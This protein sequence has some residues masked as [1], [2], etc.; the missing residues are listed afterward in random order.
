MRH[1]LLF[2]VLLLGV[3][4][5]AAQT[6][7]SQGTSGNT[8]Q[9]T[10]KGCLSSSGGN[11]MLTD[12]NGKTFELTGDTSKLSDHV[13]HEIKVTGTAGSAPASSDGTMS[14]ASPTLEV[15]SFKHI[16]KTCE[17]AGASH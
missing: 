12:K 16:S 14:Q 13:G 8:G 1:L 6:P 15:S 10:V 7:A 5:A 3:S 4:W 9:E 2:S 11:Y 17:G